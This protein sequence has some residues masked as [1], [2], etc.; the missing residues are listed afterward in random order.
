MSA[1]LI[2]IVRK[3][4]LQ[5]PRNTREPDEVTGLTGVV[6]KDYILLDRAYHGVKEWRYIADEHIP[7]GSKVKVVGVNGNCLKV[8]TI[9]KEA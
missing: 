5:Q 8:K 7:E 1:I 3:W 2:V 4:F 6:Q 9:K